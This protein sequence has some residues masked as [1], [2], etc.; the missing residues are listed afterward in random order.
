MSR[1]TREMFCLME[2]RHVHPSTLYPGGT[3]T[4][5]TP[6]VF[7]DYLTK[8]LKFADFAKK[9][10]PRTR[11]NL[12]SLRRRAPTKAAVRLVV[13]AGYALTI[14]NMPPAVCTSTA[15]VLIRR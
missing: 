3:G 8:L 6:Q 12:P 1:L 4:V 2:G 10:V 15:G 5:V 14:R 11:A 7:T 13:N 9:A